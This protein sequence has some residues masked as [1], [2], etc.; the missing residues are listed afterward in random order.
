M[1]TSKYFDMGQLVSTQ[2]INKVMETDD[3]FSAEVWLSLK[4]YAI[5]D[6]GLL[7]PEDC[8]QNDDALRKPDD[9]YLL[10]AYQ[11]SRGRIWIITNRISEEQDDNVTTVLFPDEM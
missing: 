10:G 6:W 8:K 1:I 4:R 9:L 11:T 3:R 7:E 5:K 2:R